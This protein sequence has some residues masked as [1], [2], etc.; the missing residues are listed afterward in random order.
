MALYRTIA[1]S[2]WTDTKVVDDFT[3]EDRYFY[4][5][6]FTNPYTNLCGCYEISIKQMSADLGYTRDI[7]E[8]LIERFSSI[9]NVIRYCVT[10]KEIL[11][12]NWHKYNWTSSVKFRKPLFE[13]ISRIKCQPFKE[14]LMA[15]A[16]GSI[17]TVSIPYPYGSDTSVANTN[18]NTVANTNAKSISKPISN[19][20]PTKLDFRK[21]IDQSSVSDAVKSVLIEFVD[22][23][24]QIKKPYTSEIGFRHFVTETAKQEK[25]HGSCAVIDCI[26]ESMRNQWQGVFYDHIDKKA[27]ANKETTGPDAYYEVAMEAMKNGTD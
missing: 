25:M 15:V 16:E 10:T 23:R 6:L 13:E 1:I 21:I 20:K 22:Y 7:C 9:H 12:L 19:R 18:A 26:K 8:K 5:Y 2:F 3:P 4:L 11:L 17:D 24:N 14:Y 27:K